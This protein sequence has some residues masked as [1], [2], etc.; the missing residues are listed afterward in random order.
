MN[1]MVFWFEVHVAPHW[2]CVMHESFC[3]PREKKGFRL[4]AQFAVMCHLNL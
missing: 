2:T 3:T 4:I 1:V